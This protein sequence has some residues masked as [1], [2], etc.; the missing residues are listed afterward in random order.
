M[1]FVVNIY[2]GKLVHT[3]ISLY[4][5]VFKPTGTCACNTVNIANK[6]NEGGMSY[7]HSFVSDTRARK[8]STTTALIY[9]FGFGQLKNGPAM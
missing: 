5:R 8:V 7:S 3:Y 6:M 4:V 2:A 1:K 9:G